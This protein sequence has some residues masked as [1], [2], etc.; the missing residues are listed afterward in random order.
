MTRV[1]KTESKPTLWNHR[2]SVHRSI[3]TL[4]SRN[5]GDDDD[6]DRVEPETPAGPR[7]SARAAV[8]G[9]ARP[10]PWWFAAA[11]SLVVERPGT[12]CRYRARRR[13]RRRCRRL[14]SES[15]S[16]SAS[17]STS[18]S[19][20]SRSVV[21]GRQVRVGVTAPP[22]AG[23]G[24]LAACRRFALSEFIHEIV[25]EVAHSRWSLAVL[26]D[27]GRPRPSTARTN[28]ARTV[29]ASSFGRIA[30]ARAGS[31]RKAARSAR[32]RATDAPDRRAG[33]SDRDASG[34]GRRP[35][36]SGRRARR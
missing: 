16:A 12:A 22:G 36:G 30:I 31:N 10:T 19:R 9:A 6:D 34:A 18:T 4:N 32:G 24:L 35:R 11:A 15:R 33:R 29:S 25:E 27:Q 21:V 1:Q 8:I 14:S 26:F 20:S 3:P 23:S 28:P 13:R 2:A 17:A 5:I 7:G